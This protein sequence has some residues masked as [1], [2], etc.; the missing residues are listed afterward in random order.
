LQ[1]VSVD[2]FHG[3]CFPA[4]S[5]KHA[6]ATK[7]ARV[8]LSES[9]GQSARE[10]LT[11][12]GERLELQGITGRIQEEHRGLLPGLALE[13]SVRFNDEPNARPANTLGQ[14]FPLILGKYDA[15]MR[16]GNIMAIDC[17]TDAFVATVPGDR[18]L[19]MRH[20]LMA[21]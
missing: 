16:Y 8:A 14:C 4:P 12:L 9:L 17:I 3:D 10:Q 7:V 5:G 13:T 15:K 21:K 20:D 2:G 1:A 11:Q 19:Q 18:R 6:S